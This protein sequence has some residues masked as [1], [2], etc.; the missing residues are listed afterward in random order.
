NHN[1]KSD[2]KKMSDKLGEYV[3]KVIRQYSGNFFILN[4]DDYHNIHALRQSKTTIASRPTHM[5]TILSKSMPMHL[6][7]RFIVNLGVSYHD[8]MRSYRSEESSDEEL[9]NRL[10][11]HSYNDRSIEKK[12]DRHIRDPILFDFVEDKRY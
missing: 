3:E 10:V 4:I 2:K 8:R 9:I 7:N 6:G 5:A 1:I 12:K 11:I